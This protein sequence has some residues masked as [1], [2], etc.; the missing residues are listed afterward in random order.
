MQN[1]LNGLL[2]VII[3]KIIYRNKISF[4]GLPKFEFTSKIVL[5]KRSKISIGKQFFLRSRSYIAAVNGS[6]FKIGNHVFI[7]RNCSMVCRDSIMIGDHCI[8]G[9]NVTIYD[10]DHSFNYEG[11]TEG[12]KTTPVV[13][14]PNCWIGAGSIILRGTH[15]GE[16]CVIG[17]GSV[18]KGNIPEHSMVV[19]RANRDLDIIPI[20]KDK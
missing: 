15:I 4:K 1:K 18:V 16:G 2:K 20:M 19:S 8:F 12:Y 10:H 17:A 11:V 6:N 9:P 7:N 14:E 13:I 3:W 5:K